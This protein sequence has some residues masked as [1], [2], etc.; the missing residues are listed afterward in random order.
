MKNKIVQKLLLSAL[1]AY[2]VAPILGQNIIEV[3]ANEQQVKYAGVSQ[4]NYELLSGQYNLPEAKEEFTVGY[5]QERVNVRKSPFI[6]SEIFEVY[7]IN[8]EVRYIDYND[9]W[10]KIQYKEGYAYIYKQYI[11]DEKVEIYYT[12]YSVPHN[13]GF[14]AYMDWQCITSVNSNQYKLQ[15]YAYTS[16]NGIRMV[17]GRYCAALG[18]GFDIS[19]GDYVD[20]V[21]ENETTIPII[22]AD[23]KDNVH[24]DFSNKVTMHDGSVA[25]FVVSTSSLPSIVK[26][27]GDISY[28]NDDWNEEIVE[29]K[30]YNKNFFD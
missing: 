24:T 20:L 17:D 28:A 29:V 2:L 25:E 13:S 26:R 23:I 19:V 22:I 1:T 7:D 15:Q 10:C 8:T 6:G 14:K 21:L 4:F 18:T 5:T 16:N 11:G 3:K 27:M 30:K 12:S 9:E